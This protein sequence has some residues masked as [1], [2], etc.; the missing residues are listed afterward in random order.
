[1]FALSVVPRH[2]TQH[3]AAAFSPAA[4]HLLYS[5]GYPASISPQLSIS[6]RGPEN[7][8]QEQETRE[9]GSVVHYEITAPSLSYHDAPTFAAVGTPLPILMYYERGNPE[10]ASQ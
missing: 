1:M 7:A 6:S 10:N 8:P 2:Y 5:Q 3:P 9:Q 4:K